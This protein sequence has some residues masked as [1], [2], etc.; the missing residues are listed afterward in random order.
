MFA[1]LPLAL[2]GFSFTPTGRHKNNI[3]QRPFI[4]AFLFPRTRDYMS[5]IVQK[6][7]GSSVATLE[8]IQAV[9]RRVSA[10]LGE[11]HNLVVVVSAMGDSTDDLLAQVQAIHA[12]PARREVDLLLSTGEV[13]SCAL[14]AL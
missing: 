6:Y 13:V 4:G 5:L 7:G 3:G 2:R 11:G 12:E 9:A 1:N 10:R 8:R 14:M